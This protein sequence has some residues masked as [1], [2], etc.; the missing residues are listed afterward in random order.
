MP[1]IA[2]LRNW[3]REMTLADLLYC[4]VGIFFASILALVATFFLYFVALA[5]GFVTD[6][7]HA[8]WGT[9]GDF[10]GGLLGPLFSFLSLIAL[11]L[12]LVL[13]N[14]E[15]EET[16]KELKQSR[17]AHEGQLAELKAQA[18]SAALRERRD[19]TFKMLERWTSS[20]MRD[21]R[22]SAWDDLK[23]RFAARLTGQAG[24]I[25]LYEY[26]TANR[27]AFGHF[28][29]VCHFFSDLNKLFDEKLLDCELTQ[30]LFADS[31]FPWFKYTDSLDFSR[32]GT[33]DASYDAS[34]ENWYRIRVMTLKKHIPRRDINGT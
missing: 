28:V 12:T 7:S 1:S 24:K 19:L 21:H 23:E 29:E 18:A 3:V 25:N 34:V 5:L 26:Q 13:Q 10:V 15:L 6:A 31:I 14:R 4:L 33:I 27:K 11:L 32:S 8:R 22:L 9:F 2:N 16:R 30:L 20:T 17:V